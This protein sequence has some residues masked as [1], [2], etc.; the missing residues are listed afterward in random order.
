LGKE[1]VTGLNKD[2]ATKL[3]ERLDGYMTLA[4]DLTS[5]AVAGP[6]VAPAELAAI[7][8]TA[9][10]GQ[11]A[12]PTGFSELMAGLASR[13]QAVP[14]PNPLHGIRL[15]KN[16]MPQI[17]ARPDNKAL[18][19]ADVVQPAILG[20]G[21]S[22]TN[23]AVLSDPV[24]PKIVDRFALPEPTSAVTGLLDTP[25]PTP[26]PMLPSSAGEIF[27]DTPLVVPQ[28]SN[29]PVPTQ[30]L[31]QPLISPVAAPTTPPP[32]IPAA[33]TA[34]QAMPRSSVSTA[35]E[36]VK[37]EPAAPAIAAIPERP[38]ALDGQNPPQLSERA[39][40]TRPVSVNWQPVPGEGNISGAAPQPDAAPN[41]PGPPATSVVK[42]EASAEGR[43][44]APSEP[45]TFV[46]AAP[47][48]G[49]TQVPSPNPL[50]LTDPPPAPIRAI[51][52]LAEDPLKPAPRPEPLL[53]TGPALVSPTP[54]E[55]VPKIP[56]QMEA[57]SATGQTS[58]NPPAETMP[59]VP[60]EQT[61][62]LLP[63]P[64]IANHPDT[65]IAKAD[66]PEPVTTW[67][68][69]PGLR[70]PEMPPQ[71]SVAPNMAPGPP[72]PASNIAPVEAVIADLPEK[73]PEGFGAAQGPSSPETAAANR[74]APSPPTPQIAPQQL[75]LQIVRASGASVNG[76]I[77]ITL[78]PA[79]LGRLRLTLQPGDGGIMVQIAADRPE[80]LELI[81]KNSA[82]L[83]EEFQRSGYQSVGFSFSQNQNSAQDQPP[84]PA[85]FLYGGSGDGSAQPETGPPGHIDLNVNQTLDLRL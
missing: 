63:P 72:A 66:T 71:T 58:A 74:V 36:P 46:T 53:N 7:T 18:L 42:G 35:R 38:A 44:A 23:T 80:T 77:E 9:R 78:D 47:I 26:P 6:S 45:N 4:P 50:G 70:I 30:P 40:Y 1:T 62:K 27:T 43:T 32:A 56:Q 73:G 41:F 60:S 2:G 17:E 55:A 22:G 15:V 79:E 19:V 83:T 39:P 75:A 52:A 21:I 28:I 85:D 84:T 34:F 81:R 59:P 8:T 69:V 68:S 37:T 12:V 64:L 25:T 11:P 65:P 29:A 51:P 48:A 57:A 3:A 67:V 61:A 16:D 54:D 33:E 14:L 10:R 13:G 24:I 5:I 76:A 82:I 20:G 49:Q 31:A